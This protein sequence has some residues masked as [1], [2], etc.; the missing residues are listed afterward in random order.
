MI[1]KE[2]NQLHVQMCTV[3]LFS[4]SKF[5]KSIFSLNLFLFYFII[6]FIS[7]LQSKNLF[8]SHGGL[9]VKLGLSTVSQLRPVL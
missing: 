8:K 6:F 1:L 7:T 2:N 3:Y 9:E 5:R 4:K